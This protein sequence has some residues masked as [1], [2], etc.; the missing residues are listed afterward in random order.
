MRLPSQRAVSAGGRGRT[1]WGRLRRRGFPP[2]GVTAAA[3]AVDKGRPALMRTRMAT[4][5]AT[6]P[7]WAEEVAAAA[8]LRRLPQ[9]PA[10]A[11]R[12]ATGA[13]ASSSSFGRD[14]TLGE[15]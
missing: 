9:R 14:D 11:A 13:T 8:A 1:P 15:E 6:R 7:R 5:A 4:L 12:A 3:R 2:L 10:Q